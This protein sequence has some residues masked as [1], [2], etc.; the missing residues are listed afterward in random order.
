MTNHHYECAE[1]GYTWHAPEGER[2]CPNC[3]SDAIEDLTET[4]GSDEDTVQGR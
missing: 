2:I 1:C 3:E 4:Q